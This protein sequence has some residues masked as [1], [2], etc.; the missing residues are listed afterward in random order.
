MKIFPLTPRLY[1]SS[2]YTFHNGLLTLSLFFIPQ[3]IRSAAALLDGRRSVLHQTHVHDPAS[4]PFPS[5]ALPP[6]FPR[7]TPSPTWP[8]GGGRA[9]LQTTVQRGRREWRRRA[10]RG[11]AGGPHWLRQ[12]LELRARCCEV[13]PSGFPGQ[14]AFTLHPGERTIAFARLLLTPAAVTKLK[15]GLLKKCSMFKNNNKCIWQSFSA[16]DGQSFRRKRTHVQQIN[17][18]L[19]CSWG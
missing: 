13:K 11:R 5:G 14:G 10:Q 1:F 15:D 16:A 19:M 3:P 6:S 18:G 9:T 2:Y 17:T 12:G 8:R 4:A 7:S